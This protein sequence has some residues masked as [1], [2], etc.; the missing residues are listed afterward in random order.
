MYF[1]QKKLKL[2]LFLELGVFLGCYGDNTVAVIHGL[3]VSVQDGAKSES[4]EKASEMP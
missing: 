3:T 4:A 1:E 2:Y